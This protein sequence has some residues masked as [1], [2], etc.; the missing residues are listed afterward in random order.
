MIFTIDAGSRE[1]IY[2]QLVMQ[3]KRALH[4][5]SLKAGEQIPSM[6]DLAVKLGISRETVKK[7]YG[8]LVENGL[9]VPKH[10]KGFF[11]ADLEKGGRPQVLVLFD[12]FS[13]YKQILFNA[14]AEKIGNRADITIVNHNQNLD[15]FTYYLDNFLDNFD[16]YVVTPHF[17]LDSETQE[18]VM[19]QLARIPNRKLI[20]LDR[21]QPEYPG[22]YGAAFLKEKLGLEKRGDIRR[23]LRK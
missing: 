14:F 3:V 13:V 22:N 5:G 21:L 6:N 19:K 2:K 23:F 20:M 10:G 8:V 11:A 17:P 18:G 4:D 7:A 1:P 15:L 12:K 9:I 16:Y